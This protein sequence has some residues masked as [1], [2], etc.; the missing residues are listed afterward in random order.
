MIMA[1]P[2]TAEEVRQL[3]K[4]MHKPVVHMLS[5]AGDRPPFTLQEL[6]AMEYPLIIEAQGGLMM[7]YCAMRKAYLELK[8][9][10]RISCDVAEIKMIRDEI[11]ALVDL[12]KYWE[13]EAHTVEQ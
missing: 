6:Y 12:P 3:P 4:E 8:E 9:K 13:L 1:L 2:R 10:G 7:A 11:N 5:I